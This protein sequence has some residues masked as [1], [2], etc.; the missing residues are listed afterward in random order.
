MGYNFDDDSKE[1][2]DDAAYEDLEKIKALLHDAKV[3]INKGKIKKSDIDLSINI[4]IENQ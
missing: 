2:S 4:E 1:Y 3:R